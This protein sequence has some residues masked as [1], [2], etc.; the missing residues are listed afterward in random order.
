MRKCWKVVSPTKQPLKNVCQILRN[1]LG[2]E[3][4]CSIPWQRWI[5]RLDCTT[6]IPA[7]FP[8]YIWIGSQKGFHSYVVCLGQVDL[9]WPIPLKD[10][11]QLKSSNLKPCLGRRH[12]A[13]DHFSGGGP[14]NLSLGS[15]LSSKTVTSLHWLHVYIWG[16][17]YLIVLDGHLSY[18]MVLFTFLQSFLFF[19]PAGCLATLHKHLG[20]PV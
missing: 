8:L 11:P 16:P 1:G 20:G 4:F 9:T 14:L 2:Q 10:E 7:M 15:L 5:K 17:V 12:G 13:I 18:K 19:N 3:L 6:K